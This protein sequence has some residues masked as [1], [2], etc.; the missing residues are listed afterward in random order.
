MSEKKLIIVI[1]GCSKDYITKDNT[2]NLYR[3]AD[4]GFYTTIKSAI[5]SVTNVNHATI[6]SGSFPDEHGVVGNYYYNR[7]TK[8]EGFIESSQH[9]KKESILDIYNDMGKSTALL[10]VKG[11]VLEIFGDNVEFKVN[12]Q[13]PDPSLIGKLLLEE[14]PHV[15]SLETYDWIFRACYKLIE[16]ENPDLVYLTT[17]DYMMH[18][19]SPETLEA[20]RVMKTIDQWVGS[21][22][23]LD[24][25]REIYITADHGMN[26]KSRLID[27]Q[28]KMDNAGFNTFCLLALKDRYLE[29]HSY[30]EGGA[31]YIYVL[32]ED[33]KRDIMNHLKDYD[34]VDCYYEK[35]DASKE[36]N[37]PTDGIGDII[38]LSKKEAAFAELES[39]ELYIN[40]RTHGSL[41]EREIPLI[42]VNARRK[43]GEYKYSK[44]IVKYIIEDHQKTV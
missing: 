4:Q 38:V 20:E 30:Q 11:K 8:E 34:F 18:N 1:D 7:L 10:T 24:K 22:Y 25:N 43:V 28:K 29:N 15:G 3:I 26:A 35:D 23:E 19:Y 32:E 31:V 27:M 39:E 42:A 37:M 12:L 6:L 5:P 13:K 44:D 16:A 21:I 40:T 14:P 36:F 9:M 17:N 33:Q 41:H 2:P